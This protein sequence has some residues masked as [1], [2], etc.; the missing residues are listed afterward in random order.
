M[1]GKID[2][3]RMIQDIITRMAHNSFLLK[4]WTITLMMGVIALAVSGSNKFIFLLAYIPIV[5]FWVLDSY[6]LQMERR[7]RVLYTQ[8][9]SKN[10]VSFSLKP[11]DVCQVDKTWFY[12]SFISFSTMCIYLPLTLLVTSFFIVSFVL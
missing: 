9:N 12:Q 7:Y 8:A 5:A 6:Y 4:G 2:Y 11:P 10:D 3:L 1:N